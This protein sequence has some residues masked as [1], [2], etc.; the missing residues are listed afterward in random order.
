M[1]PGRAGDMWYLLLCALYKAEPDERFPDMLRFHYGQLDDGT[2]YIVLEYPTPEQPTMT[3][4]EIEA[5]PFIVP[6]EGRTLGVYFS[7]LVSPEGREP[8]CFV[9]GQS[10]AAGVTTLRRCTLGAHYNLGE[11]P[12]PTLDSFVASLPSAYDREVQGALT[13]DETRL[14]EIDHA[15]RAGLKSWTLRNSK[16][17]SSP[18][19]RI[20]NKAPEC[21][22]SAGS[23]KG[24]GSRCRRKRST[25]LKP[26]PGSP[27]SAR[28]RRYGAL[29]RGRRKRR[30]AE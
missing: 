9:L 16:S 17:T 26:A 10:P 24:P 22:S 11:G 4:E 7:A 6:T 23:P 13:T 27:L 21:P 1:Q 30:R 25:R 8:A 18:K 12:P 2:D 19:N 28:S 29:R 3:R 15:L 20:R 5:S 14:D